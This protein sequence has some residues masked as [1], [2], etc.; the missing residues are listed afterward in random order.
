MKPYSFRLE[1]VLG[2]RSYLRKRAQK[3]VFNARNKYMK[4][5]KEVLGLAEKRSELFDKCCEEGNNGICVPVYRLYQTFI[6]KIDDDLEEAHVR[7][8]EEKEKIIAK[9][10]VLKHS[11]IKKKT[12]EILKDTQRKK[13]I[14]SFQ[15][16][17][18]KLLDEIVI[19][20]KGGSQ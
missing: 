12:L 14:E 1:K 6:Q 4:M 20:G 18:Q 9:E 3:A 8:N 16:E 5:E 10:A 2:Y 13:Y 11:S 15:R 19:I 7:L 17:E